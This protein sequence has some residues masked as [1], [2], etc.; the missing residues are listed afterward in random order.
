MFG[1]A[2]RVLHTQ[3]LNGAPVWQQTGA[4]TDMGA[5]PAGLL[6]HLFFPAQGEPDCRAY[7][8]LGLSEIL[9]SPPVLV[10]PAVLSSITGSTVS[11]T[12]CQSPAALFEA[13]GPPAVR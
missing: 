1:L 9:P 3:Q 11:A 6:E 2:H 7:D 8:Q 12:S 5:A 4:T 10:P 13:W